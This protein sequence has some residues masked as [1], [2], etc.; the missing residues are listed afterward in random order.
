MVP[1]CSFSII[2]SGS[3]GRMRIARKINRVTP[4]IVGIAIS[5]RR[6]T[7]RCIRPSLVQPQRLGLV[8]GEPDPLHRHPL[9]VLLP[10]VEVAGEADGHPRRLLIEEVLDLTEHRLSFRRVR[11]GVE[12]AQ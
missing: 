1:T 3:P 8:P 10:H 12:L 9:Q 4:T 7:Y 6:R 2:S 5:N 11:L